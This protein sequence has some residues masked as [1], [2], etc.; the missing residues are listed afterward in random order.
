MFY[1]VLSS[2]DVW[3]TEYY[4]SLWKGSVNNTKTLLTVVKENFFFFIWSYPFTGSLLSCL[5]RV[6]C[7]GVVSLH[8]RHANEGVNTD[9]YA[10][11]VFFFSSDLCHFL[12]IEHLLIEI[13]RRFSE[14]DHV[15]AMKTRNKKEALELCFPVL[16]L[17]TE[18][19]MGMLA[20]CSKRVKL[21]PWT[22]VHFI[23]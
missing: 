17:L 11:K 22:K 1:V 23:F 12:N 16:F 4:S 9:I 10:Y 20:L 6:N 3:S 5:Y 8:G 14:V 19:W 2:W 15:T 13:L 18:I 7:L 21:T